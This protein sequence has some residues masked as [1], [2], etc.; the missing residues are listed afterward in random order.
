MY[1]TYMYML[2]NLCVSRFILVINEVDVNVQHR[3]P[4]N[5][6][7]RVIDDCRR[8]GLNTSY[9]VNCKL[10]L[11]DLDVLAAAT[12]AIAMSLKSGVVDL[13]GKHHKPVSLS[14]VGKAWQGRTLELSKAYKQLPISANSQGLCVLGYAYKNKW[15]DFTTSV[16][17]FGAAAAVYGFN[18]V[19]RSVHH[20]LCFFLSVVCICYY[21]D[22]PTIC[23][24]D[25]AALTSRCMSLF[26]NLLE[27]G[28]M[29]RWEQRPSTL[30]A[31]SQL[32]GLALT[33]ALGR[34][35]LS[36]KP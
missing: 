2:Y 29:L 25:I 34:F 15:Q 3:A 7:V 1:Y 19:S 8:S 13:G 4:E 27:D 30:T 18:R 26:L 36:N 32:L 31:S 23:I 11:L 20:T 6:R 9:T 16:L 35:V 14:V 33:L 17:L 22:F 5:P 24:S 21:D 10:E 28:S 12:S